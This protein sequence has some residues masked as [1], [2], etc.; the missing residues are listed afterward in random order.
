MSNVLPE[1]NVLTLHFPVM[2]LLIT[3]VT[4]VS[5]LFLGSWDAVLAQAQHR[6]VLGRSAKLYSIPRWVDSGRQGLV[7]TGLQFPWENLSQDPADGKWY[8]RSGKAEQTVAFS[9]VCAE[10]MS[11]ALEREQA[12][13]DVRGKMLPWIERNN[14]TPSVSVEVFP[15]SAFLVQD[16]LW[17]CDFY[18][19]LEI[20]VFSP[21]CAVVVFVSARVQSWSVHIC[22]HICSK[23]H[24]C[25]KLISFLTV[26]FL[27]IN[28]IEWWSLCLM[29]FGTVSGCC[30][31]GLHIL[32]SFSPLLLGW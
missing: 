2:L 21:L 30:E 32:G 19:W 27:G 23:D 17:L 3:I 29:W 22:L 1:K 20:T 18:F 4:L 25:A 24:L 16:K 11:D 13:R 6:E 10:C 15:W 8:R 31:G 7:W 12:K 26:W 28:F 14:I 9:A 5:V